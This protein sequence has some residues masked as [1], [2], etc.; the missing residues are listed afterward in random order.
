[1]KQTTQTLAPIQLVGIT[2][3]TNN[4]AEMNPATGKIGPTL[5]RYFQNNLASKI[6]ARKNPGTTFCVYTDYES[7]FNGDYTYFVGEAV[8]ALDEVDPIFETRLIPSQSYIQ[9]TND[10]GPMPAVCI[11]LWQKIWTMT[12]AD[13]GGT[14]AY[15]A[16]F[17]IYDE[18]SHDPH[19]AVLDI[20]I[21]VL[22]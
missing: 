8:S 13:L 21:G 15:I 9:F 18:R 5:Q 11:E 6:K 16:D 10:P 3:R 1:M 2:A 14:R 19:N 7:D 4:A 12:E 17:E 22:N 20:Y